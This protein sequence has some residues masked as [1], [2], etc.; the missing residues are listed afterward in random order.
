MYYTEN[1]IQYCILESKSYHSFQ[2]PFKCN[3]LLQSLNFPHRVTV[4][5]CFIVKLGIRTKLHP[6][7]DVALSPGVMRASIIHMSVSSHTPFLLKPP[8]QLTDCTGTFQPT[9]HLP[10]DS[11]RGTPN[12]LYVF[13]SLQ[14]LPAR[15]YGNC[16]LRRVED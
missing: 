15:Y 11:V 10:H 4:K 8:L 6:V 14:F 2:K 12:V 13:F 7:P 5:D 1:H 16:E 3:T 9:H